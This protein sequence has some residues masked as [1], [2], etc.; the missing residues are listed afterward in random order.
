M[1]L[2]ERMLQRPALWGTLLS[3]GAMGNLAGTAIVIHELSPS[4]DAGHTEVESG[5]QTPREFNP[6]ELHHLGKITLN[7]LE[8]PTDQTSH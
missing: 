5:P 7:N 3:L 2:S 1:N 8:I 4:H 6:A